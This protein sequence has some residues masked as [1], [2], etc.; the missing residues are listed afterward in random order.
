VCNRATDEYTDVDFQCLCQGCLED[1]HEQC[2][3]CEGWVPNDDLEDG[4]CENCCYKEAV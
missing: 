3:E 1:T 4:M 2:S